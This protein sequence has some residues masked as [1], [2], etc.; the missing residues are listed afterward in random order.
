MYLKVLKINET[1]NWFFPEKFKPYIEAIYGVYIFD[2]NWKVNCCELTPSFELH[3][4]E[5]QVDL[6][7]N[8]PETIQEEISSY[9]IEGDTNTPEVSYIHCYKVKGECKSGFFP[10]DG[11][12]GVYRESSFCNY[13]IENPNKS[14]RKIEEIKHD[15]LI[16]EGKELF[17][18]IMA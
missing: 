14:H 11:N 3:F 7:F 16:E 4:I 9:I 5:S 13:E 17:R 10:K 15:A 18:Q 6:D 1:S 8:I 2:P 12:M